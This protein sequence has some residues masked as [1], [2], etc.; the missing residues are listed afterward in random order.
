MPKMTYRAFDALV[1]EQFASA[2]RSL[3]EHG[4][5]SSLLLGM[6]AYGRRVL[7]M[8]AVGEDLESRDIA[9]AA[10]LGITVVPGPLRDYASEIG[11]AFKRTKTVAAILVGETWLLM[12][13]DQATA[14][15]QSGN[16]L[17]DHPGRVEVV[18]VQGLWPR[19]YYAKVLT[20]LIHRD[21]QG[22]PTA[23]PFYSFGEEGQQGTHAAQWSSWLVDA[24]PAPYGR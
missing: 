16:S 22:H 5:A 1:Q 12:G 2:K 9:R 14:H 24:L 8:L 4:Y 21:A 17:A 23:R 13:K 6:D 11:A 19:E 7:E 3:E 20:A 18:L 15:V 10:R